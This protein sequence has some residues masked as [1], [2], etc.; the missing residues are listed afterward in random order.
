MNSPRKL[1][2]NP[3]G[4]M[5]NLSSY[6]QQVQQ[7]DY[8]LLADFN[9]ISADGQTVQT[10]KIILASQCGYYKGLFRADPTL[11][12]SSVPVR[13]VVLKACVESLYT[14]LLPDP[15]DN[16]E[17]VKE[18]LLAANF[19]GIEEIVTAYS[20]KLVAGLTDTNCFE[21]L[22]WSYDNCLQRVQ[23]GASSHVSQ[24][25]AQLRD[26]VEGDLMQLSNS[27]LMLGLKSLSQEC[28]FLVLVKF[29]SGIQTRESKLQCMMLAN[30]IRVLYMVIKLIKN[31]TDQYSVAQLPDD[32]Q[33]FIREKVFGRT[34]R[35]KDPVN[36]ILIALL[37]HEKLSSNILLFR[38]IDLFLKSFV[39]E[40][41]LSASAEVTSSSSTLTI[42]QSFESEL[43]SFE[44]PYSHYMSLMPLCL[45]KEP[46]SFVVVDTRCS[47]E[48]GTNPRQHYDY[49]KRDVHLGIIKKISIYNGKW[50]GRNVVKGLELFFQDRLTLTSSGKDSFDFRKSVKIGLSDLDHD[51][52]KS[53]IAKS[54]E[55]GENEYISYVKGRKGWMLDQI[56]FVTNLNRKLGPVGGDGGSA[57]CTLSDSHRELLKKNRDSVR[58]VLRGIA[59][60]DGTQQG[61]QLI[62]RVRFISTLMCNPG[63]EEMWREALT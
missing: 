46:Q 10:H 9:L 39:L 59:A 60:V 48:Y 19:L 55:L 38:K 57:F 32:I 16:H 15:P 6:Y 7:D 61:S 50:D 63:C 5:K 3:T 25:L 34:L 54:F 35:E 40:D 24:Q 58:V 2:L 22:Q 62:G 43:G 26:S 4:F 45:I 28:L 37:Q 8:D 12:T 14:S 29:G 56:T 51:N 49:K 27:P 20:N 18:V 53:S 11:T 44:F 21:L 23:E 31:Y 41:I 52:H 17:E 36:S 1:A 33:S 13:S 30:I 47:P 42:L